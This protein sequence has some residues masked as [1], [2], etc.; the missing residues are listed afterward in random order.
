MTIQRLKDLIPAHLGVY[1]EPW[2]LDLDRTIRLPAVGVSLA[3]HPDGDFIQIVFGPNTSNALSVGA[4]YAAAVELDEYGA[5][6]VLAFAPANP[7]TGTAG[8]GIYSAHYC[9][10]RSN[11][12]T[13]IGKKD[14]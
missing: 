4:I 5:D 2:D 1:Y 10:F 14:E 11:R 8:E 12:I 6:D 9:E 3:T 7:Q 13:I